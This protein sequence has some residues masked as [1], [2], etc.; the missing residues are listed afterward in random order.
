MQETV[1]Y[2]H[3]DSKFTFP[4]ILNLTNISTADQVSYELF[5]VIAYADH[6]FVSFVKKNGKWM[7]YDDDKVYEC[8]ETYIT[9]LYGGCVL[10]EQNELWSAIKKSLSGV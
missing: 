10:Q 2:H 5:A 6:H 9:D 8:K 1:D 7:I 3:C 4:T